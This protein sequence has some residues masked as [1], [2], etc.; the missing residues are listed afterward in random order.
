MIK[1][2]V[3][4]RSDQGKTVKKIR[5]QG[6][7]PGVVYGNSVDNQPVS[8]DKL[9]FD[10]IYRQVGE[11]S[12]FDLVVDGREPVKVLVK[13]VQIHPT[14]GQVRHVDFHQIKMDEKLTVEVPIKFIGEPKAVKELGG[15]LVKNI[16]SIEVECLPKD[17]VHE[18]EVD[19]TGLA[20]F[21]KGLLIKEIKLPQGLKLI[22]GG[23]EVLVVVTEPRS[24]A[25]LEELKQEV[26]E[27]VSKIAKVED[28]EGK[29]DEDE[30]KDSSDK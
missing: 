7:V 21:N 27:D 18:I 28:K 9:V 22:S 2:S 10:K 13:E 26:K 6:L 11:S 4:S 12:L 16:S 1:L 14:T 29:E 5:T 17:L 19:I 23:E 15:I 25:E 30:E 3:S 24:E 20:E 8:V